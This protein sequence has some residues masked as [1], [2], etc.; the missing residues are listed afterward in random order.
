MCVSRFG[1][2]Q[3][4]SYISRTC[5]YSP[6]MIHF[7]PNSPLPQRY[8]TPNLHWS[9][10][11][12]RWKHTTVGLNRACSRKN[13]SFIVPQLIFYHRF[14]FSSRSLLANVL[15]N[16]AKPYNKFWLCFLQ[17]LY[18]SAFNNYKLFAKLKKAAYWN[19]VQMWRCCR[20]ID[21]QYL[22]KKGWFLCW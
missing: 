18:I 12:G 2:D 20:H 8:I 22:P 19:T 11:R 15:H 3:Q 5:F 14:F 1:L 9:H 17:L 21:I 10:K 16:I 7:Y 4:R 13:I 6:T